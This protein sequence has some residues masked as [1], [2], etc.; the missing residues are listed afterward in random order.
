[1]RAKQWLLAL[2]L[3]LLLISS[4]WYLR[5]G[6]FSQ[7][8][9]SAVETQGNSPAVPVLSESS[10]PNFAPAPTLTQTSPPVTSPTLPKN[11]WPYFENARV[12]AEVETPPD[13]QGVST[14]IRVLE[15]DFKY[16]Y[17]RTVERRHAGGDAAARGTGGSREVMVADHVLVQKSPQISQAAFLAA[18]ES[19]GA[20][21]L[22]AVNSEGLYLI[23]FDGSEPRALDKMISE[24]TRV[25][26][27]GL[28]VEP[29][30]IRTLR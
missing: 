5:R 11:E 28:E 15:T 20:K 1:M 13:T 3:G 26:A 8:R 23:G 24:L 21:I 22:R 7:G 25:G 12:L 27:G 9:E 29:D 18:I 4:I 19:V 6:L 17:I 2:V 10:P 30:Y 16:P 14:R